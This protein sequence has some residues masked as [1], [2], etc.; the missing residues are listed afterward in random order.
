MS[1]KR[2]QHFGLWLWLWIVISS[3]TNAYAQGPAP[4]F[5][6]QVGTQHISDRIEALGT[7]RAN[8]AVTL[9]A[10]VTE[11]IT[12]IHFTDGQRV[13]A[14]DVLVAMTNSEEQA[15][16][17]EALSTLDEAERQYQRVQSLVANNLAPESLLDQR[18]REYETAKAR[19]QGIRSRLQDRLIVA[20]F[21]GVVGL[22]DISVGALV[23]PGDR[24]TTLDDDQVMKLDFSVPAAYLPVLKPGLDIVATASALNNA[25]FSGSIASVDF[26]VDPITRS[27]LV[28][29][30]LPNPERQLRP[31]ILMSVDILKA[32]R[33][34]IV[35]PEAAII[36]EA[37]QHSVWVVAGPATGA[38]AIIGSTLLPEKRQVILGA[39]QPGSVEIIS[40]LNAGEWIVTHGG[41]RIRPGG[42]VN[43]SA[44]HA[45][46]TSL[47]AALR[48]TD[49]PNKPAKQ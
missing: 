15:L 47:P 2:I 20:P 31:G 14:G 42:N 40:G 19:L 26:R 37:R 30:L 43:V 10:S 18:R 35:I 46:D 25:R 45:A 23:T 6:H 44:I 5:V 33:D 32:P 36:S 28:R 13:R 27:V 9:T 17:E 4:V 7:L 21:D 48:D 41:L 39:R 38:D 29:A 34:A 11:T 49:K 22:R 8:E 12:A 3:T 16:L 24:I 1:V